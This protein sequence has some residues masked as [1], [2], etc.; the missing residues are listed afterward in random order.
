MT[1]DSPMNEGSPSGEPEVLSGGPPHGLS[2][3]RI[4]F[5]VVT[6]TIALLLLAASLLTHH[7][8]R[9]N[10]AGTLL[11][12]PSATATR[13][14]DLVELPTPV[15]SPRTSPAILSNPSTYLRTDGHTHEALVELIVSN[16]GGSAVVVTSLVIAGPPLPLPLEITALSQTQ[17]QRSLLLPVGEAIRAVTSAPPVNGF[18]LAGHATFGIAVIV[19]PLCSSAADR[20][21]LALRV[22]FIWRADGVAHA[23]DVPTEGIAPGSA[24]WFGEAIAGACA[25]GDSSTARITAVSFSH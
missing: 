23:F 13:A 25:L 10:D 6:G 3:R 21:R 20:A 14:E 9:G 18:V 4:A 11:A 19:H 5:R 8:D 22:N 2:R 16:V 17:V 12:T 1:S 15:P 7:L 24:W